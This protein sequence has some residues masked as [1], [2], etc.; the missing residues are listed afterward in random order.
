MERAHAL[1][2]IHRGRCKI[3]T[4]NTWQTSPP[5]HGDRLEGTP[6][7]MRLQSVHIDET[8]R[9][10]GDPASVNAQR[11]MHASGALMWT[12]R[13]AR[14]EHI[15]A[16]DCGRDRWA[17]S[18]TEYEWTKVEATDRGRPYGVRIDGAKALVD[19]LGLALA[20]KMECG[21]FSISA[22]VIYDPAAPIEHRLEPFFRKVSDPFEAEQ[23]F[24]MLFTPERN[25]RVEPQF[26]VAPDL[27]AMCS[28]VS[29][30]S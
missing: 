27:P 26:V 16:I 17:V 8:G 25:I 10:I 29:W 7:E 22:A 9:A 30:W 4:L 15:T 5:P 19:H 24:R 13:N 6:F 11:K 12:G 20:H 18:F 14:I 3:S 23:E 28:P 2:F 1:D 21:V